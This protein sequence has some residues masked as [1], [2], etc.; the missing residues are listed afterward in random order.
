MALNIPMPGQPGTSFLEGIGAGSDMF[1]KLMQP[2]MQRRQMAQQQ[3]QHMD[4]LGIQQQQQARLQQQF[5]Q[6]QQ[7]RAMLDQMMNGGGQPMGQPSEHQM[8]TQEYGQGMGMFTPEGMQEA[9]Q[10]SQQQP[11]GEQQPGGMN[12]E[13]IKNNPMLRGLFKQRFG[14]DPMTSEASL[15]G[16][17][18]EAM[19]LERLAG[20]LPGGKENPVYKNA[21]K[22][23]EGKQQTQQDLSNVRGRQLGGL[24]PG[25]RWMND[26]ESGQPI[27]KE[28]PLSSTERTEAKGRG[29][30]NY[31]FPAISQ[32]LAPLSG[33]GSI[34]KLTN[35]ASQYGQNPDAT[36]LID[37]FLLSK[38]LLTA[39]TVKEAA[40]LASGKQKATYQQLRDSLDSSDIPK[41]VE[42]LVKQFGLPPEALINAD[43]RFSTMLN[44]ATKAGERSIPA[45]NKQYFN[46]ESQPP[47][48]NDEGGGS[49]DDDMITVSK[50]DKT[51]RIPRSKLEEFNNAK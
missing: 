33:K 8:P 43:K 22:S 48:K 12:M 50:W 42:K 44:D 40:T 24:K 37:D 19:D 10:Q 41:A 26:P 28:T 18:R 31:T 39:G 13:A 49:Q 5:A 29:F 35:A 23:Y 17:A 30:F 7:D 1:A 3:Q 34:T 32:G 14:I 45:Y 25:E 20:M 11:Q 4:S 15:Q 51:F 16:P 27:G 6:E 38:K 21:V 2:E 47:E 46:P 36:K 9:Q